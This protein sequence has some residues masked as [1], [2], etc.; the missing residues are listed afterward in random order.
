MAVKIGSARSSFGN[1]TPG[2][3]HNGDEVS[4]QSWYL[5]SK[6]W[7]VFRAKDPAAREKIAIA[8]ERA[9]ANNQIGY[10][11]GTRD[12][13]RENIKDKGF[14]PS[15]TTKAV[16]CDC[17]SLVRVCCNFA[18]IMVGN[19]YTHT[20]PSKLMGTGAFIELTGDKYTKKSDY[21]CRGDILDTK[22]QGHTV[23][24][25]TSGPKCEATV[26]IVTYKLGDRIL[27]NG[28]EGD[29]V[30]ELQE[31]LIHLGYS[32]GSWGADGEFGDATELAVKA[33]Q[34]EHNCEVDGEVGKETLSAMEALLTDDVTIT[35]S[36]VLISGGNCYVRTEP[37]TNGRKLGVAYGGDRLSFA[38]E[39]SP[40]GWLKV[41]FNNQSG[42]VSGK[43]G[44][45]VS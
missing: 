29:D 2:D 37:N 39:V 33:F 27:K 38:R 9:C 14:D 45:V 23:V 41:A 15:K 35:G 36:S 44:K 10:S 12:S 21:L 17:S 4:T 16:N 43:Y 32:C 7:R 28:S 1:T 19:F 34:K 25:L 8:M 31:A 24:V 11:Q 22:T 42:W 3:Q 18:G 30:K 26:E 40:E 13:L 20:E 5:H 6:G